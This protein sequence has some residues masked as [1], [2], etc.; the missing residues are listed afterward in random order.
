MK[1]IIKIVLFL[2][3]LSHFSY[4]QQYGFRQYNLQDGLPQSQI[5]RLA[6][7]QYGRLWIGTYYGGV[8][9]FDGQSFVNYGPEEGM[10]EGD[11]VYLTTSEDG[12]TYAVTT[13]GV[14]RFGGSRVTSYPLPSNLAPEISEAGHA[15]EFTDGKLWMGSRNPGLYV[16]QPDTLIHLTAANGY[17]DQITTAIGKDEI[18]NLWF[19]TGNGILLK[20][21]DGQIITKGTLPNPGIIYSMT[22]DGF[23]RWWLATSNGIFLYQYGKITEWLPGKGILDGLAVYRIALDNDG[24]TWVATS[25]GG[26]FLYERGS[27]YHFGVRDGFSNYEVIDVFS[28]QKGNVWIGS[29]GA[30]LFQFGGRQFSYLSQYNGL[31]ALA[32]YTISELGPDKLLIHTDNSGIQLFENGTMTTLGVEDGLPAEIATFVFQDRRGRHW[33][34]TENGA[35]QYQDG[36]FVPLPFSPPQEELQ[37]EISYITDDAQGNLWLGSYGHLFKWDGSQLQH[38]SL[39]ESLVMPQSIVDCILVRKDGKVLVGADKHVILFDP[40]TEA[41]DYFLPQQKPLHSYYTIKI[42][43]DI[44]GVLWF[45]ILNYGVIRYDGQGFISYSKEEG[46]TSNQLYQMFVDSH[47]HRWVG[48]EKGVDRLEIDEDGN[49]V[50][51]IHY[52]PLEGF[53]GQETQIGAVME[54]SDGKIWFGT[55]GGYMIYN[56]RYD[57]PTLEPPFAYVKGMELFFEKPDWLAYSDALDSLSGLPIDLHLPYRENHITFNFA[58]VDL[59]YPEKVRYRHR[60]LPLQESWSPPLPEGR[61]VFSSLPP[62]SYEF[63]VLAANHSGVWMPQNR[64]LTYSFVITPPFWRTPWFFILISLSII[65]IITS[66]VRYR[67]SRLNKTRKLLEEMVEQ[68][69]IE[70]NQKNRKLEDTGEELKTALDDVA[71]KNRSITQSIQYARRIQEAVFPSQKTVRA[72]F[73][74]TFVLYRPKDIVSG[75]FLWFAHRQEY[76]VMAVADCTGHGVPGA[77]MSMIGNT[78]LNQI[79][80]E[81]RVFDPGEILDRLRN[82]VVTSL[83]LDSEGLR[84]T[85]GMD[86]AIISYHHS[87]DEL[88]FAGAKRPLYKVSDGK[89]AEYKGNFEPIGYLGEIE[90]DGYKTIDIPWLPG[91]MLYLASD[92]YADQFG[93]PENKK[94]MVKGLKDQLTHLA[95][96]PMHRQLQSLDDTFWSWKSHQPQTDDILVVGLRHPSS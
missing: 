18:G 22:Q 2:S 73:P 27:F 80:K 14:T 59:K 13:S 53:K 16:W 4:S 45:A 47:G 74:E 85:D 43:E 66:T 86:V 25:K 26:V 56:P 38:W 95:P 23:D 3:A 41:F 64:P 79:V 62:G 44:D 57:R 40:T 24:G 21:E 32:G 8:S 58:A 69:T 39:P 30:G 81:N 34:G 70:L 67:V 46:L 83:Q 10:M 12:D 71:S 35:A 5:G 20:Q 50:T 52:G 51:V 90:F 77:F 33:V 36:S 37:N 28:D 91:E 96:D 78:A 92:G 15:A 61:A 75:D 55:V 7:D 84:R 19:G 76:S 89:L 9:V 93:G 65:A 82:H 1:T 29:D 6:E 48:S 31:N 11:V 17:V 88:K 94:I 87:H 60:L 72:Y 63:Q 54:A 68:R 42:E 49:L